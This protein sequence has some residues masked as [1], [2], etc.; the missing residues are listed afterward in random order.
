[1]A[2]EGVLTPDRL[3][4]VPGV[5]DDPMER[6]LVRRAAARESFPRAPRYRGGPTG[7]A[8][9]TTSTRATDR[10]LLH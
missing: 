8:S 4:D 1:M 2:T 10:L 5:T 7:A 6:Q 3:D 9:A